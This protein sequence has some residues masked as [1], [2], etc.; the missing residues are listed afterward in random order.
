MPLTNPSDASTMKRYYEDSPSF[1]WARHY[2][3]ADELIQKIQWRIYTEWCCNKQESDWSEHPAYKSQA[4]DKWIDDE[5][6][7]ALEKRPGSD[8]ADTR[9]RVLEAAVY[10]AVKLLGDWG[11]WK[12]PRSTSDKRNLRCSL[13]PY[14]RE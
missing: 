10:R 8:Y 9:R 13:E 7:Y 2:L 5:I 12:M 14:L 3:S 1:E 11:F 4:F 6:H